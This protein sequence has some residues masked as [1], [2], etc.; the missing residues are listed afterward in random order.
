MAKRTRI[1][2]SSSALDRLPAV[3]GLALGGVIGLGAGFALIELPI[4]WRIAGWGAAMAAAFELARRGQPIAVE[5]IEPEAPAEDVG[6]SAGAA[7]EDEGRA[8]ADEPAEPADAA[9]DV[10]RARSEVELSAADGVDELTEGLLRAG[11][12]ALTDEVDAPPDLDADS[13]ESVR[14]RRRTQSGPAAEIVDSS[15]GA[16]AGDGSSDTTP[17]DPWGPQPDGAKF[18]PFED[19]T[20]EMMWLPGGAFEMG[21]A[22]SGPLSMRYWAWPSRLA[23]TS[24]PTGSTRPTR[25]STQS[26]DAK[27]HS[28]LPWQLERLTVRR[29]VH[30][31]HAAGIEQRVRR[32]L[33]GV[34]RLADKQRD[35]NL[36]RTGQRIRC[37]R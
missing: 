36:R 14:V 34:G 6:E 19:P 28:P 11:D 16:P 8:G 7:S 18:R 5:T 13:D 2:A 33:P 1:V 37:P 4:V 26:S 12:R 23:P 3:P 20:F 32:E 25:A 21:S 24:R 9:G 30:D 29:S 22:R 17:W 10:E 15:A 27:C 31:A 35:P